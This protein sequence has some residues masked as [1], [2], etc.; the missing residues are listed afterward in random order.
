M[1]PPGKTPDF[2]TFLKTKAGYLGVPR[3]IHR[4]PD[5]DQAAELTWKVLHEIAT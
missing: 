1:K 3:R 5:P 4:H 2:R